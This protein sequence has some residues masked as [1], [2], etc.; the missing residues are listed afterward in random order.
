VIPSGSILTVTTGTT[1]TA[2][3]TS[4]FRNNPAYWVHATQAT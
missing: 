4:V 2:A 1:G 3:E